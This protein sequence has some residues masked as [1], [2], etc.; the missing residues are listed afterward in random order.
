MII[1]PNMFQKISK[2]F[3]LSKSRLSS[4]N[5]SGQFIIFHLATVIWG[6]D[7]ILQEGFLWNIPKLWDGQY[8][9]L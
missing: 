2:R 6:G 5:E 3:H 9:C 4:L 7:A 1:I 8:F